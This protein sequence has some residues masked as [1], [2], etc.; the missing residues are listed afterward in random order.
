M[1]NDYVLEA[2]RHAKYVGAVVRQALAYDL[3]D[4]DKQ[5]VA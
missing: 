5:E 2:T 4:D 3:V 1:F